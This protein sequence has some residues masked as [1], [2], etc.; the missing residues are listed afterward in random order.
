MKSREI[1]FG[2]STDTVNVDL[3]FTQIG[4]ANKI[5]RNH[6]SIKMNDNCTFYIY[7]NSNKP[8]FVDG[9]IVL[10]ACKT[11][12]FDKSIIQVRT[13]FLFEVLL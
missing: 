7:N 13:L 1:T 5:S 6:G 9:K 4:M 11:Q 10:K 2:R 3:D 8:L 12:L